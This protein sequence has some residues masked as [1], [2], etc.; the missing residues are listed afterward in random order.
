MSVFFFSFND[1]EGSNKVGIKALTGLKSMVIPEIRLTRSL[2][3]YIADKEER[4]EDY[5]TD[6][7]IRI[8]EQENVPDEYKEEWNHYSCVSRS[9][10]ASY[11][12]VRNFVVRNMYSSY[13]RKI[14]A[15]KNLPSVSI[16]SNVLSY[17]YDHLLFHFVG[18]PWLEASY[19]I[20]IG[21]K[22][23]IPF[24]AQEER[25]NKY[26][27]LIA[28]AKIRPSPE[29]I[30]RYVDID[31]ALLSKYGGKEFEENI[32]GGFPRRI[33]DFAVGSTIFKNVLI[34]L[35]LNY[36]GYV[37]L[38]NFSIVHILNITSFMI[39]RFMKNKK[40]VDRTSFVPGLLSGRHTI[41]PRGFRFRKKALESHEKRFYAKRDKAAADML[42]HMTSRALLIRYLLDTRLSIDEIYAY[43]YFL[44]CFYA[45][46]RPEVGNSIDA[47]Y[48]IDDSLIRAVS[49]AGA[50]FFNDKTAVFSAL[51][52][53]IG[54]LYKIFVAEFEE[55]LEDP[56]SGFPTAL[57]CSYMHV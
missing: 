21:K 7:L 52:S 13:L 9:R 29:S 51:V 54:S 3:T 41:D 1:T 40:N 28:S 45:E 23:T 32:Q 19:F 49:S 15:K 48:Y 11:L 12:Y 42:W 4:T 38:N 44:N 27:D 43:F 50:G 10:I 26:I 57:N 53:I 25:I 39:N 22:P 33:N 35:I 47:L 36:R 55:E 20:E 56:A 24:R 31:Y 17:Y 16:I 30:A 37:S 14:Y 18:Y 34:Y 2:E 46:W 5:Y 6:N 8:F